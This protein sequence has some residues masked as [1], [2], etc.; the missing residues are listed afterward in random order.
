MCGPDIRN[1]TSGFYD[2]SLHAGSVCDLKQRI[3]VIEIDLPKSK[4]L[5]RFGV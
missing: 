4:Y 5:D 3:N 1:I 2:A